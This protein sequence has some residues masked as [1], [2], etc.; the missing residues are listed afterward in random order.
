L[1]RQFGG[2]DHCNH[3]RKQEAKLALD[4][5][6]G[7]LEYGYSRGVSSN[8]AVMVRT[9]IA[10]V[11]LQSG[12]TI[13]DV[14][15]G[16]GVLDRWL[17]QYTNKH[18]PIVGVDVNRY[19][20]REAATLVQKEALDDL[21]TLQEGNAE[22]LPF[23]D[24]SFDAVM[25]HTVMEEGNAKKMLSEMVR[26]VKPGGRVAVMVRALDVPWS[27]NVPLRPELKTKAEI[28][29]GFVGEHG[30]ADASLGKR[31]RSAGLEQVKMFPQL[32]TFD[33]L[34][35]AIG[36]FW[37]TAILGALDANETQEW[38]A[39]VRQAVEEGTFYIAQSHQCAVGIKP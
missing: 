10:E 8:R 9:L 28:P 6:N 19:L 3:A 13:L 17:A 7:H 29:G 5:R 4:L 21:I 35:V 30:C 36:Q 11:H 38:Q 24:D 20:L 34:N 23:P 2:V 39:G 15:C 14:G 27:V 26:V 37:E 16:S 12:E 33:N 18:N 1:R 31:F 25:S 32:A 22:D